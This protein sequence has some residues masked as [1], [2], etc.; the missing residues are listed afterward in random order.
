MSKNNCV[1]RLWGILGIGL[2]TISMVV[3]AQASDKPVTGDTVIRKTQEAMKATKDFTIQQK[4]AFERQIQTELGEMKVSLSHLREQL[5]HAS[6]KT[7]AD[8]QKTIVDLETKVDLANKKLQN[9]RSATTSSWEQAKLKTEAVM[10]D[11]RN[12]LNRAQSY[13]PSR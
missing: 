1:S 13:L 2:L 8:L 12:S 6:G 11:L 5:R 3:A 4:D 7:R 9:M 10:N